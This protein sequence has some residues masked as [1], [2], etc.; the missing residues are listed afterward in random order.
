MVT[1]GEKG[2]DYLICLRLSNTHEE[3]KKDEFVSRVDV[4]ESVD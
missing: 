4:N 1:N 3:K 2:I